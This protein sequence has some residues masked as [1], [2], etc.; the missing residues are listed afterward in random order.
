MREL[1]R[2]NDELKADLQ[3][4]KAETAS[5]LQNINVSLH[6]LVALRL[7]R[8]SKTNEESETDIITGWVQK[9]PLINFL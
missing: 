8:R 9:F 6:K 2:Q 3:T 7:A 5:L 1:R 4:F